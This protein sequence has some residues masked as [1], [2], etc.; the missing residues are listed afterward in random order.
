MRCA[1]KD[2]NTNT[3]KASNIRLSHEYEFLDRV[4]KEM[5]IL[6]PGEHRTMPVTN[7]SCGQKQGILRC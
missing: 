7:T 1:D 5:H 3:S 6:V 4:F 2:I